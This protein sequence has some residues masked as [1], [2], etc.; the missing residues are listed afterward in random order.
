ME[1]VNGQKAGLQELAIQVLSWITCAKRPLTIL[2]L[3]HALAVEADEPDIDEENLPEVEDMVAVCAGLVRTDEESGIIRLAHYTTQEYFERTWDR[4]FPNAQHN[5]AITCITYLAFDIFAEGTCRTKKQ[6]QAR[7][8]KYPLYPYTAQY[9]G[10]H[11]HEASSAEDAVV[12][13]LSNRA[14]VSAAYQAMKIAPWDNPTFSG[15][16][17]HTIYI[18]MHW[19]LQVEGM[20]LAAWFGL[21]EVTACLLEQGWAPDFQVSGRTPLSFAAE[22]GQKEVVDFLLETKVVAIDGGHHHSPLSYAVMGGKDAV[23]ESL[24]KYGAHPNA[25]CP[26]DEMHYMW[27]TCTAL[28][29]AAENGN[30]E[31]VRLLLEYGAGVDWRLTIPETQALTPLALAA[32]GGHESVVK[33]LLNNG[34]AANPKDLPEIETL[35]PLVLAVSG[36]HESVVKLL[37]NNGAT[38]NP[39]DNPWLLSVALQ[40]G[41][42]AIAKLLRSNGAEI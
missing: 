35:T 31:I 42:D 6:Y 8:R 33:L 26:S 27:L 38:A 34:A 1:R 16:I 29:F 39:K 19:N 9:W 25:C 40:P 3:Q 7:V 14:K 28:Q 12:R 32:R 24:L 10:R 37:L 13:F 30:E 20:H 11:A 2:E 4:W 15:R 36:G 21:K 22:N 23:V 5:I 18:G 41:H 17:A